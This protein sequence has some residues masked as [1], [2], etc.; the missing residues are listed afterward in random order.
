VPCDD[1]DQPMKT[2]VYARVS[3]NKQKNDLIRQAE[4][5][6]EFCIKNGWVVDQVITEIAS[7]LNDARPKLIKLLEQKERIRIVSEHKD[8]LTRFGFNYLKILIHG[9]III[10]NL[11]DSDKED[12]MQDLI[13]LITSMVVRYYGQ[14]RGSKKVKEILE[15]L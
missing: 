1:T 10:A 12:L 2:I 7:G 14:R 5:M 15:K 9:E 6:S 13:S 11:H 8:R 4:R 3:S